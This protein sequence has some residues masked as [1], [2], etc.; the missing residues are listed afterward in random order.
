[1]NTVTYPDIT[2]PPA[3]PMSEMR[4]RAVAVNAD[5]E[6]PEFLG[7]GNKSPGPKI[8]VTS[9]KTVT[10][11][12]YLNLGH[13]NHHNICDEYQRICYQQSGE[14]LEDSYRE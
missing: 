1:M 3:V 6:L 9:T 13:C 11:F 8:N 10:G 4:A 12:F 7:T 2:A 5:I 14:G